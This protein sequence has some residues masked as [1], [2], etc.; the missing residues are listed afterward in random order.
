MEMLDLKTLQTPDF[1]LSRGKV[2]HTKSEYYQDTPGVKEA[3][4]K[5]WT[6]IGTPE[7][8][9]VW[10][11]TEDVYIPKTSTKKVLYKLRVPSDQ[12]ICYL[13]GLVWNR[14]LGI[15]CMETR[16]LRNQWTNQAAKIFPHSEKERDKYMQRCSEEFWSQKP[17]TGSWWDEL[18]VQ[19]PGECVD[20]LIRHPVPE[21]FISRVTPWVARQRV[22]TVKQGKEKLPST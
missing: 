2:D 16:S 21:N 17:E 12:F 9:I 7:G 3:Y 1:P 14:I 4:H 20:A 5:L 13:D 11:Y 10:C 22:S 15:K 19:E 18:I 8:Q 6:K